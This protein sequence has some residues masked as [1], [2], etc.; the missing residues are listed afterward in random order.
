VEDLL[1][2]IFG[3]FDAF[4]KRSGQRRGVAQLLREALAERKIAPAIATAVA[5]R[6][7]P[8]PMPLA[9]TAAAPPA[10]VLPRRPTA[11]AAPSPEAGLVTG[12]FASPQSLVAAFIV[13]EVLAKPVAL[14]EQ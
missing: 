2:L 14:R 1:G 10:V 3:L 11:V 7:A 13:A 9:Q 4:A 6:S 12:L 8:R 5:P